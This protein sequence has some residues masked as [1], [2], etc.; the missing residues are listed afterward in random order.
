MW[1]ELTSDPKGRL[2]IIFSTILP[3][4][5]PCWRGS[6]PGLVQATSDDYHL[7]HTHQLVQLLSVLSI[8]SNQALLSWTRL[9]NQ[10]FPTRHGEGLMT[11]LAVEK[12]F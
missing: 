1:D 10:V 2:T 11:S 9:L 8:D 4:G 7:N 5:Q 12:E 6:F 3:I